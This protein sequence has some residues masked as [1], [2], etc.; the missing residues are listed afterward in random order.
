MYR[1]FYSF[2]VLFVLR[3]A[4]EVGEMDCYAFLAPVDDIAATQARVQTQTSLLKAEVAGL[5]A[6]RSFLGTFEAHSDDEVD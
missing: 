1:S 4:Q 5:E 2:G 6:A 3:C